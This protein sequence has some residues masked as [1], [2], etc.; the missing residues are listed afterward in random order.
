MK[1]ALAP[2]VLAALVV[3]GCNTQTTPKAQDGGKDGKDLVMTAPKEVA[4]DR[5]ATAELK[6]AI[7]RKGF[8]DPVTVKITGLPEGVTVVEDGKLDK[9]VKE[10]TFTLKATP[11]APLTKGTL[12]VT[13]SGG[14]AEKTLEVAYDV[15]EKGTEHTVGSSPAAKQAA[16]DLQKKRDELTGSIQ[17]KMK[18]IDKSM[19]DLRVQAKGATGDAKTALESRLSALEDQRKKLDEDL[20]HV[21]TTTAEAWQGFSTRVTNAANELHKGVNEAVNKLKEKKK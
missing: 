18:E 16:A 20:K 15:R 8:E 13:A 6:I 3:T 4:I 5:D 11:D 9:G 19:A 7:D 12:K 14:G 21:P 17:T 2:L 10:R 1:K